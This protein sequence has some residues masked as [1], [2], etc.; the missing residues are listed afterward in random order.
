[1]TH[2]RE[3]NFLRLEV[4]WGKTM[5]FENN[6][7][8]EKLKAFCKIDYEIISTGLPVEM[9][10]YPDNACSFPTATDEKVMNNKIV[11]ANNK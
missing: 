11:Y 10:R 5:S 7:K 6:D 3:N 2:S 1:M 9:R 4:C 8:I